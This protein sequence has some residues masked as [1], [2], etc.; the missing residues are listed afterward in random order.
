M[1]QSKQICYK[2]YF[3]NN[4]NN[5]KNTLKGIKTIISIENIATT[6][7]NL[8]NFNNRTITDPTAISIVLITTLIL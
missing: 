4:W 5:I 1:K 8:I 7:T 2:K 6:I 3:E